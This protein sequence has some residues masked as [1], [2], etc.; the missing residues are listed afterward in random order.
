MCDICGE[1]DLRLTHRGALDYGVKT[2]TAARSQRPDAAHSEMTLR[3]PPEAPQF[4]LDESLDVAAPS[5]AES[6]QA[7]YTETKI[8]LKNTSNFNSE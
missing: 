8:A 1:I 7:Q 4:A 3:L 2:V 5:L 6:T